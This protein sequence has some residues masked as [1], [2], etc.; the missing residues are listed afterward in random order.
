MPRKFYQI[1]L[2]ILFVNKRI[3]KRLQMFSFYSIIFLIFNS[4]TVINF[5]SIFTVISSSSIFVLHLNIE[6]AITYNNIIINFSL[7]IQCYV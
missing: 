3:F 5:S 1:L 7:F 2:A 4:F 6:N